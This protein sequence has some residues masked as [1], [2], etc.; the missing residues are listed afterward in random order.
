MK[1]KLAAGRNIAMKVPPHA[2]DATV[3]FY[4]EVLGLEPFERGPLAAAGRRRT[5]GP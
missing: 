4:G 3:R 5:R 1:P 2:Y